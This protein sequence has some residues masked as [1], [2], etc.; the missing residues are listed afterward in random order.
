MNIS[1]I[2]LSEYLRQL[3]RAMLCVKV[4]FGKEFGLT[5]GLANGV[6]RPSEG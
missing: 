2:S 3:L 6:W 5:V 4:L 1:L